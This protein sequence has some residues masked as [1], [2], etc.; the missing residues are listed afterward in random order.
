MCSGRAVATV[1]SAMAALQFPAL[2]ARPSRDSASRPGG[3]GA[4]QARSGEKW[5]TGHF[6]TRKRW[7]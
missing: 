2:E 7:L 5:A 3:R 1:C 4:P 6:R